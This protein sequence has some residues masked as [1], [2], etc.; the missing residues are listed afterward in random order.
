M[1]KKLTKALFL[2]SLFALFTLL[3]K[4]VDVKA[5]G[6]GGSKVGFAAINGAVSRLLGFKTFMYMFS[7]ICGYAAFLVIGLYALVGFLQL[8]KRKKLLKVDSDILILGCFYIAVGFLYIFFNKVIMNFRPVIIDPAEGLE[9]S[10]PSSH[11][12]LSLCVFLSAVRLEENGRNGGNQLY[13]T[14]LKVMALLLLISR[15]LSGCH[16]FTD[17]IGGCLLSAALLAFFDWALEKY[18]PVSRKKS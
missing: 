11:T 3:I 7:Q 17:I 1:E 2:T 15:L 8:L 5:I 18:C 14:C 9:A 10:Y 16:W 6:P 12:V 4:I 13:K